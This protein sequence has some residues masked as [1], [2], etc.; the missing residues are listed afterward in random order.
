M[1]QGQVTV[2]HLGLDEVLP[3][4]TCLQVCYFVL[5]QQ[6]IV[7]P[8]I[9]AVEVTVAQTGTSPSTT[10]EEWGVVGAYDAVSTSVPDMPDL[11]P[12]YFEWLL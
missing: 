3:K 7:R 10:V 1:E 8:C 4:N 9:V 11:S 12:S 2:F 6:G 5:L